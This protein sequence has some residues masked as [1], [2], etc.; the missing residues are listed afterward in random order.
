[1]LDDEPYKLDPE[2][3][4]DVKPELIPEVKPKLRPDVSP[5]VSPV[6]PYEVVPDVPY[7]AVWYP[8]PAY[9]TDDWEL[10]PYWLDDNPVPDKLLELEATDDVIL[11][12]LD[13][14]VP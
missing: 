11:S 14:E 2:T 3:T 1:M 4:S 8:L 13:E 9:L 5:E 12:M 10:D 7:W 6:A